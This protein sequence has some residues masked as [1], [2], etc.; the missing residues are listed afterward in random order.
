[1]AVKVDLE[2]CTGCE[3]CAEV[4]PVEAIKIKNDKVKIDE[5]ECVDCG[6]CIDE[7][8]SEALSLD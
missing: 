2:E 1:M 7:C 5:D 8:E 6:T 3:S 4:C